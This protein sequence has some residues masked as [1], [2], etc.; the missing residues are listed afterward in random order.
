M[1]IRS[2]IVALFM[3]FANAVMAQQQIPALE[4]VEPM[5]WWVG[6]HNPKL[7]LV[8]HGYKIADRSVKMSYP[9]V[10]LARVHKVENPNYLFLDLNISSAARPGTFL[11]TFTKPGVEPLTYKYELW[12]HNTSP[13]IAQGVTNKD[14]IYLLMPDRFSNGDTIARDRIG[15]V[16]RFDLHPLHAECVVVRREVADH[17][18]PEEGESDPV[19][20]AAGMQRGSLATCRQW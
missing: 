5:N 15:P 4:R 6:M 11:L 10:T 3:L 7:Q 17:L 18:V 12:K 13:L 14:L 20:V 9:G 8:V 19:G 16:G 2:V 1:K